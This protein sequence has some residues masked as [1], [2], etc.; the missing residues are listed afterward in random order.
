MVPLFIQ[1]HIFPFPAGSCTARIPIRILLKTR[2]HIRRERDGALSLASRVKINLF[3]TFK[4]NPYE[5]STLPARWDRTMWCTREVLEQPPTTIE[6][7]SEH[8]TAGWLV[9]AS[10]A[11]AIPVS[12]A[13]CHS[14]LLLPQLW[15]SRTKTGA[16]SSEYKVIYRFFN[17]LLN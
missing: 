5:K 7:D 3:T 1:S 15:K 17:L 10:R 13:G 8:S 2:N 9:S 4:F 16:N 6:K 12:Q 14:F 11:F